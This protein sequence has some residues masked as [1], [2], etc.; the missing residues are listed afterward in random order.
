MSRTLAWDTARDRGRQIATTLVAVVKGVGELAR[1]GV[2]R[3]CWLILGVL[4][5]LAAAS[6]ASL[7]AA[8]REIRVPRTSGS[9]L[10]AYTEL[11]SQGFRV[12]IIGGWTFRSLSP[13]A[14][15]R[16]R[17]AASTRVPRGA[18]VELFLTYPRSGSSARRRPGSARVPSFVGRPV[19]AADT[20]AGGHRLGLTAHLGALKAAGAS[21][22][23]ANFIVVAQRPDP[24]H[25]ASSLIVWGRQP[26]I[27][28]PAPSPT[29]TPSPTTGAATPPPPTR[30]SAS[31]PPVTAPSPAPP[32]ETAETYY[33]NPVYSTAAFPDPFVLDNGDTHSDYWAFAT[34]DLFPILHS[35]DLVRW[36]PEGTAMSA[37]PI[38]VVT[39]GDWHPWAPGVVQSRLPCPGAGSDGCYVMYYVGLSAALNRNCIAVATSPTSG[40]P[41]TDRGPLAL[42]GQATGGSSMPIGCGD[43]DGVGNIDPSPFVDTSGQAYLYLSTSNACTDGASCYL[44]PTISVIPLTADLLEASGPRTAL[45]SGDPGTWEAAAAPAPTV[46]GPSMELHNGTYYLFYSGGS[47]THAYGMGYASS[48]S[49]TGPFTESASNPFFAS[50]ADAFS[51]GGGDRLVT[52]PHGGLWMVYAARASSTAQRTLWIDPFAWQPPTTPGAPDVPGVAG[53]STTPQSTEP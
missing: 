29:F 31:P 17:P 28:A 36:T 13:P 46:E 24:G 3:R 20:W 1:F 43:A 44:K 51:V 40:G 16:T 12:G 10:A 35:A 5:V 21:Q 52:G 38:W 42:A 8:V 27:H 34:G 47:Y 37:R 6:A 49:P 11:H 14:V 15:A 45:F 53:P 23:L 4:A 32:P 26:T 41:Y 22:L 25:R 39:S 2:G 7:R 50:A 33:Q 9:V 30:G 18:V 48:S 19:S